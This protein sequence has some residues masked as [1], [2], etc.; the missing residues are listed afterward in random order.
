[1]FNTPWG[2]YRYTWLPFGI[3]AARDIFIEE[4][5]RILGYLPGIG[6]VTDDILVYGA[7]LEKHDNR[8]KTVLDRARGVNLKLNADK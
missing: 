7:T 5:Q 3:K 2:R 8:L 1:M 6:V 4:M